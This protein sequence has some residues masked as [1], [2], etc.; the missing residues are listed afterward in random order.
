MKPSGRLCLWHPARLLLGFYWISKDGLTITLDRQHGRGFGSKKEYHIFNH[1][2]KCQLSFYTIS[3]SYGALGERADCVR[4]LEFPVEFAAIAG[5]KQ[6][7]IKTQ[8]FKRQMPF[9]QFHTCLHYIDDIFALSN[10]PP[11]PC[12]PVMH[13][14]VNTRL[15]V[16][17]ISR[18][19]RDDMEEGNEES[20]SHHGWQRRGA[21]ERVL[22]VADVNSAIISDGKMF[23]QAYSISK[24]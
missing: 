8:N 10:W 15:S 7:L 2:F 24:Y 11:I 9:K 23:M 6:M 18:T 19:W 3:S 13:C 20:W 4:S 1:G 22:G 14:G 12:L 17:E 5:K 21:G 16:E